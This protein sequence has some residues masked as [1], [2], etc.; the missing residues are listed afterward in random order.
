MRKLL[1]VMPLSIFLAGWCLA[2]SVRAEL[3]VEL[4]PS[5]VIA[6]DRLEPVGKLPVVTAVAC[7][8]HS[9]L[10]VT[11]GDD[12][13]VRLGYSAGSTPLRGLS[14]PDGNP[15]EKRLSAHK[16]WV[17]SAVISPS[18]EMLATAG[19][20]CCIVLW[21]TSSGEQIQQF[22]EPGSGPRAL[23]FSP[24]GLTLAAAGFDG[25]V[26]LYD[27]STRR[28][29]KQFEAPGT[30]IRAVVFSPDGGRV[31]AAGRLG[32]VRVWELSTGSVVRELKGRG[33]R[34]NALAYS[35]DG[36]K[37]VAAGEGPDILVWDAA[38]G[39]LAASLP[40]RLG[41]VMAI[42]F[43][44]PNLLAAGGSRNTIGVWDLVSGQ[45]EFR[46]VGHTGSVT[47]LAWDAEC[48]VLISGSFDTTVRTW[49]LA[50]RAAGTVPWR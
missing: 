39:N 38:D 19:F 49:Q 40:I 30:D 26:R 15:P 12:H 36:E 24:D 41:K 23:A 17:R 42:A 9:G 34:M 21:N 50:G 13:L 18:G 48:G 5:S 3:I 45:Q 2:V 25:R 44:G 10:L 43:C 1:R 32:V 35:P 46:L 33:R 4:T 8:A 31:A 6:I 22:H 28:P 37:I 11:A 7:D 29:V 14:Q 20:D 27:V 47:S 16:D